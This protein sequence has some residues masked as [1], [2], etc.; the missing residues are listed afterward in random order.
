MPLGVFYVMTLLNLVHFQ[1]WPTSPQAPF[2]EEP[3]GFNGSQ[4]PLKVEA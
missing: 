2:K 3:S 4:S 1:V